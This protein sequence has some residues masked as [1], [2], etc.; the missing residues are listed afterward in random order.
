MTRPLLE[1]LEP[2]LLLS[3]DMPIA[4]ALVADPTA[5]VQLELNEP[6]SEARPAEASAV[7][8]RREIVFVDTG[9]E[10]W[11]SLVAD[12][13]AQGSER[14]LDVVLLDGDRDGVAQIS[15]V[16]DDYQDLDA[17]HVV[18]HGAAG[19]LQLGSTWLDTDGLQAHRSDLQGWG[20]ALADGADLL[21]YGCD[22]AG[23]AEGE[24][25]VDSLAEL[26]GADVAASV[27]L[28]GSALLGGDWD[29]EYTTGG[30]EAGGVFSAGAQ[31]GWQGVLESPASDAS[32]CLADSH[33][34]ER[35]I[36]R[37]KDQEMVLVSLISGAF[38]ADSITLFPP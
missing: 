16:L 19:A 5:V 15:D 1:E 24:A 7:V 13:R 23:S 22:L 18:S 17:V 8:E 9:V 37:G 29:L 12:L 20:D 25:L 26:T 34:L 35:H 31:A 6:P 30:I 14:W 33:F 27:D 11:E 38:F 21:F 36:I 3:A 28:T 4:D 10:D 2:R 32:D